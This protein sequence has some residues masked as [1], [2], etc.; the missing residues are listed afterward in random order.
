MTNI[1]YLSLGYTAIITI[2]GG[3]FGA[4]INGIKG[5]LACGLYC[6]ITGGIITL[7]LSKLKL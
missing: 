1:V 3:I 4:Y 5:F 7:L 6:G 2:I